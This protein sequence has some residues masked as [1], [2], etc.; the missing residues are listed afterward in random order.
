MTF[1]CAVQGAR[2]AALRELTA[3]VRLPVRSPIVERA[4]VA[5]A[6]KLGAA[7]GTIGAAMGMTPLAAEMRWGFRRP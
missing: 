7:W 3:L 4:L 2:A 1:P 5:R 6:R